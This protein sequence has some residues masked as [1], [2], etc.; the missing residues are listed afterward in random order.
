MDRETLKEAL[1]KHKNVNSQIH[2]SDGC[3]CTGKAILFTKAP[4]FGCLTDL[5]FECLIIALLLYTTGA[6]YTNRLNSYRE[7]TT[8]T[9]SQNPNPCL[10]IGF[11]ISLHGLGVCVMR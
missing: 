2:L 7:D 6:F 10:Q 3:G 4:L 1:I 9:Q 11:Q 8:R 5:S